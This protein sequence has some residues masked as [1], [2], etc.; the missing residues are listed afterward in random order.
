MSLR[1]S[2]ILGLFVKT[3]TVDDKHYCYK[4]KIFGQAIQMRLSKKRKIFYHIFVAFLQF[5]SNFLYFEKKKTNFIAE[6]YNR[7][8]WHPYIVCNF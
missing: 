2:Q 3:L 7:V 5:T 4:S 1:T 6:V 8:I